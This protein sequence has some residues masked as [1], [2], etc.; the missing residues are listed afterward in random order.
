VKRHDR[1]EVT[2]PPEIMAAHDRGNG[3]PAGGN[4]HRD[5]KVEVTVVESHQDFL[6]RLTNDRKSSRRRRFQ[7]DHG[8]QAIA[9]L[10]QC[11]DPSR[12]ARKC[13]LR[14]P[15]G[16]QSGWCI[17][18]VGIREI[19]PGEDGGTVN[20]RWDGDCF[21][22]GFP[23]GRGSGT[24]TTANRGPTGQAGFRSLQAPGLPLHREF[25]SNEYSIEHRDK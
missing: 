23:V 7:T 3:R 2:A 25:I 11:A 4:G 22:A 13:P 24:D 18:G 12:A 19:K 10:K 15:D 14:G 20:I 21:H 17:D 5:A 16:I 1:R 6:R 9:H 8:N